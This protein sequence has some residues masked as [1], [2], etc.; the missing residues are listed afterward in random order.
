MH[1]AMFKKNVW[2]IVALK[3]GEDEQNLK[4][5]TTVFVI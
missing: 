2:S 1:N 5:A 3:A 4:T